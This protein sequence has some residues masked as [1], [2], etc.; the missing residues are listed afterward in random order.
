LQAR[1]AELQERQAELRAKEVA[2]DSRASELQAREAALQEREAEF[3]A[4]KEMG[5]LYTGHR[6]LRKFR[7]IVAERLNGKRNT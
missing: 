4:K 1:H 7:R 3:Q 5:I 2:A 6:L